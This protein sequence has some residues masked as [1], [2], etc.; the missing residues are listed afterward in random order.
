MYIAVLTDVIITVSK[1]LF[2]DKKIQQLH[3]ISNMIKEKIAELKENEKLEK[4]YIENMHKMIKDLKRKQERIKIRTYKLIVR[5]KKA[6]PTMQSEPMN[7][8]MKK[9]NQL[10]KKLVSK[11][12]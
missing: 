12:K 1:I 6:F 10:K 3:E 8:F 9:Y 7:K 2:I 4:T 11:E 5:L